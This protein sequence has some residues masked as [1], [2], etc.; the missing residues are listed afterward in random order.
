MSKRQQYDDALAAEYVLGTLSGPARLHFEGRLRQ[1]NALAQSV[2]Q[3]QTLLSGLDATVTPVTPPER[4]WKRIALSLPVRQRWRSRTLSWGLA[5]GIGLLSLTAWYALRPPQL[6]P[7]VVLSG[8]QQ[9][10]WVVSTD[11][12]QKLLSITPLNAL[13]IA[14]NK[15]YQLWV[16]PAGKQP[17]SLG[18]L[19]ETGVTRVT[20]AKGQIAP[21][22]TI[23]ISLE[24]HG[25]SP[26]SLPTGPVVYAGQLK[27]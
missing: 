8:T 19:Q 18:L 11:A 20:L 16:I 24:P 10:Q 22:A 17:Q 3:W 23:A 12:E 21:G 27:I 15:S 26:T 6:T 14:D 13:A 7:L 5:A 1:E 25:G 9:G 4:V 2:A